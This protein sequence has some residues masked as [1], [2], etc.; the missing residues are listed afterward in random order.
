MTRETLKIKLLD[1]EQ[2]EINEYFEEYLTLIVS[3]EST[4]K[5]K[6]KTN[7]HHIIPKCYFENLNLEVDNS[8]E[9]LVNLLYVNHIIA[10]YYLSLCT[11]GKL[12]YQMANAF[13]KLLSRKDKYKGFDPKAD[14]SE[15][16]ILYE[17][18]K[19]YAAEVAK[20]IKRKPL[21]LETR[22][23]MSKSLKGK[24]GYRDE[25]NKKK[26]SER[27]K[28]NTY[29]KG[30]KMEPQSCLKISENR[31]GK[32]LPEGAGAK[33]SAAKTGFKYTEK[34]KQLMSQNG[35]EKYHKPIVCVETGEV[36]NSIK[37]AEVKYNIE[38]QGKLNKPSIVT[39][40][41]HWC[42]LQDFKNFE[43]EIKPYSRRKIKC[44]ETNEIFDSLKDIKSTYGRVE[45]CKID[46]SKAT[47]KGL[48]FISVYP[49]KASKLIG[50]ENIKDI[51]IEDYK[52]FLIEKLEEEEK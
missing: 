3:N 20:N 19:K 14:L 8:P 2:F 38:L 31:K 35:K 51:N 9:N 52:E 39:A 49:E 50:L 7:K 42:Y 23:K 1:T 10:H 45:S 27:M 15:Y 24:A 44:L 17:N 16:Q 37:G 22:L 29:R 46:N 11:K 18:N 25:Y 28:G 47:Y 34:S 43:I 48:H 33:I 13:F 30:K 40:G 32:P 41:Y 12:K 5:E 6:Y 4:Q 26:Q 21:S 36:F